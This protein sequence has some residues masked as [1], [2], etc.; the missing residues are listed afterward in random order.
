MQADKIT[1]QN[2]LQPAIL[3]IIREAFD[4]A[5]EEAAQ[6]RRGPWKWKRAWRSTSSRQRA[7]VCTA[8]TDCVMQPSA[9]CLTEL[10]SNVTQ[11]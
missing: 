5:I 9:C 3:R 8:V 7:R 11:G 4:A 10:L 1:I 2:P 6:R